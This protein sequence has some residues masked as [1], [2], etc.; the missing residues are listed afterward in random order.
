MP[1]EQQHLLEL[2]RLHAEE[3]RFQVQLNWDRAKSSL[4]FHAALLAL[5][6][7]LDRIDRRFAAWM[8]A[9]VAV[10]ALLG[11]GILQVSH[12]YYRRAR[13]QRRKVEAE[14]NTAFGFVTTPG[15]AEGRSGLEKYWPK[16]TSI[17]VLMHVMLAGLSVA[18]ALVYGW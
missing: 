16:V 7:G 18:G 6:A 17:L 2:L 12:G 13:N 14:L 4:A 8:F 11:A 1:A 15:M 9:F 5:I 3:V 10:S